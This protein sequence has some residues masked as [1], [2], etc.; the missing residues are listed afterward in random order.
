LTEREKE[1][2]TGEWERAIDREGEGTRN[3]EQ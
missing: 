3:R 1:Q 2:G